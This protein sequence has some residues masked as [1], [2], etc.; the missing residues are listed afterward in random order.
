[1]PLVRCLLSSTDGIICMHRDGWTDAKMLS[2][3]V[4]EE[5]KEFENFVAKGLKLQPGG[6]LYSLKKLL[7]ELAVNQ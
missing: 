1:M 4:R 5:S 3:A 7:R 6:K 2:D